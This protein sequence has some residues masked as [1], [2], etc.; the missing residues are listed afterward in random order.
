[1]LAELALAAS[2]RCDLRLINAPPRRF[3]SALAQ[4]SCQS[5]RA[6]EAEQSGGVERGAREGRRQQ[7]RWFPGRALVLNVRSFAGTAALRGSGCLLLQQKHGSRAAAP[8][9]RLS[10]LL[11]DRYAF[12]L[13]TASRRRALPRQAQRMWLAQLA[14]GLPA[15]WAA[16]LLLTR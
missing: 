11:L 5:A 16:W 12:P 10:H 1:M 13:Q 14:N 4:E 2:A 6:W 15:S 9:L 8:D 7:R 3:H